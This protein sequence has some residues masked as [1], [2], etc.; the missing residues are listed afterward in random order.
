MDI[1]ELVLSEFRKYIAS[2]DRSVIRSFNEYLLKYNVLM[3]VPMFLDD[4]S[5]EEDVPKTLYIAF[6]HRK[7]NMDEY[8]H[9]DIW[10]ETDANETNT[11]YLYSPLANVVYTTETKALFIESSKIEPVY[12]EPVP[13]STVDKFPKVGES[14]DGLMEYLV[15]DY[16][17]CDRITSE[18]EEL[19][20]SAI[21]VLMTKSLEVY[22]IYQD[23]YV[24]S[25]CI[26]SG[27]C[28]SVIKFNA[29]ILGFVRCKGYDLYN[30]EIYVFD[31]TKWNDLMQLI[32]D[33]SGVR[34]IIHSSVHVIDVTKDC[35]VY[36]KIPLSKK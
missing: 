10:T 7:L 25:K 18:V 3:F 33:N 34:D 21:N 30:R 23:I 4:K 19:I 32:V 6:C 27:E 35:D 12:L 20:T 8:E 9:A 16:M 36:F 31:K 11:F 13:F 24:T 22:D 1:E 26:P 17:E 29:E 14:P 15:L 2:C 28:T 5:T